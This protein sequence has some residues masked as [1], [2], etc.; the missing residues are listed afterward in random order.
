MLSSAL[1]LTS[2]II[3]LELAGPPYGKS[4][5]G[6]VSPILHIYRPYIAGEPGIFQCQLTLR[7]KEVRGSHFPLTWSRE[8]D[9]GTPLTHGVTNSST[10]GRDLTEY[11]CELNFTVD[12]FMNNEHFYCNATVAAWGRVTYLRAKVPVV[13]IPDPPEIEGP[14]LIE[15]SVSTVWTCIADGSTAPGPSLSWL[16]DGAAQSAETVTVRYTDP[17]TSGYYVKP[18]FAL[19]LYKT[20]GTLTL[21]KPSRSPPFNVTC[22]ALFTGSV[23][24][25][26]PSHRQRQ[27]SSITVAVGYRPLIGGHQDYTVLEGSNLTVKCDISADPDVM[28]VTWYK[29]GA[30]VRMSSRYQGSTPARPSLTIVSVVKG[31]AGQYACTASNELGVA[32]SGMS[33][34]SVASMPVVTT[35]KTTLVTCPGNDVILP[36]NVSSELELITVVWYRLSP[37]KGPDLAVV[38][39]KS[40]GKYAWGNRTRPALTVKRFTW[41]DAG[42]YR[43]DVGTAVGRAAGPVITLLVCQKKTDAMNI[44]SASLA[45]AVIVLIVVFVISV[46]VLATALRRRRRSEAE[47]GPPA[48]D[49]DEMNMQQE[50]VRLSRRAQ[51]GESN[52]HSLGSHQA[53]SSVDAA[54]RY[55]VTEESEL[56]QES[57]S[58]ADASHRIHPPAVLSQGSRGKSFPRDAAATSRDSLTSLPDESDDV[59][60][61]QSSS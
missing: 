39:G 33:R 53:S 20:T 1:L 5:R 7:P 37:S 2:T 36:C 8:R 13:R 61:E 48:E 46:T 30:P 38:P 11:V 41:D 15:S 31:D 27:S 23:M 45:V 47:R 44:T 42:S 59:P 29:D 51:R 35:S 34:V 55:Q 60:T 56:S 50:P 25:P 28:Y 4:V 16:A 58:S 52:R 43:C 54:A 9:P 19:T 49:V 40:R 32:K 14:A 10:A 26:V 12:K 17:D 3:V 6:Q 21:S 24:W 57:S 18:D 22:E